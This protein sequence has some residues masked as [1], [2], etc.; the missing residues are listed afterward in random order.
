M[1]D[2]AH[3]TALQPVR[4]RCSIVVPVLQ[5]ADLARRCLEAIARTAP[6]CEVLAVGTSASGGA[7]LQVLGARA[8]WLHADRVAG[9]AAACNLGAQAA[10]GDRLLFLDRASV[11]LDGWLEPLLAELAAVPEV[12]IASSKRLYPNGTLE[13][14]G[15]LFALPDGAPYPAYRGAPS[16]HPAAERRREPRAVSAECT[17]VRRDLFEA[18]GGFET[19]YGD[20]LDDVDLC[21]RAGARGVR[22]VYRPDSVVLHLEEPGMRRGP[23]AAGLERFVRR[24]SASNPP[25]EVSS[26]LEDGFAP[27]PAALREGRPALPVGNAMER[28]RW[29]RV[30]ELERRVAARG[31][32][33]VCA[34]PPDPER[35]PDHA[36]A[37]TWGERVCAAA[38]L[39]E[40]AAGFRA[41]REALAGSPAAAAGPPRSGW[42]E[43]GIAA[44]TGEI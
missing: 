29:E 1:S 5:R 10:Q 14:A 6:G 35:W 37:L 21:L 33:G 30:A 41:R 42:L 16:R 9:L 24:W 15:V 2:A 20:G 26:L 3:V 28:A 17:L 40:R 11:P 8:R 36:D 23:T 39:A 7:E 43:R 19:A 31:V 18:L 4:P 22:I 12:G 27:A 34:L 25:D 44:L 38:G 13:H 32:A